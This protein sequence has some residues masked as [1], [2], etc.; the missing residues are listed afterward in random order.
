MWYDLR[1]IYNRLNSQVNSIPEIEPGTY[2]NHFEEQFDKYWKEKQSG[3][4]VKREGIELDQQENDPLAVGGEEQDKKADADGII[5]V[6][7]GHF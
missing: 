3:I 4:K 1:H 5:H 7:K 6:M 2:L